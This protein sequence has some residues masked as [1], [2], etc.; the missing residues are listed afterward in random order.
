MEHIV[1]I[2]LQYISDNVLYIQRGE[3]DT[4]IV[5]QQEHGSVGIELL[6]SFHE[7]VLH[8]VR[9]LDLSRFDT[10]QVFTADTSHDSK[11]CLGHAIRLTFLFQGGYKGAFIQ[12]AYPQSCI[13]R[14]L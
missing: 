4:H 11:P 10:V 14:N 2:E 13:F 8:I 1:N 5:E 9:E 12:P 3:T 6:N 7:L